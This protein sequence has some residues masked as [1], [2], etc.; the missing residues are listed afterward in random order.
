[1]ASNSILVAMKLTVGILINSVSVI[2]EAIHSAVDLI[3]ALIAMI[4]VRTS[5]RP[6]DRRHAFGHGKIENISGTVEALLI[7][8]AAGWIV[9]EAVEKLKAP[10]HMEQVSWGVLVMTFS[11]IANFYVSYRLFQVGEE[12]DSIALKADA[13]HLRTDVWTSGG[14]MAGLLCYWI[15]TTLFPQVN[16]VWVDPA[17]AIIVA[18]L[19][20]KAAYDLTLES[21]RD[22]LDARLGRDDEKLVGD[23]VAEQYPHVLS[24]HKLRTRKS[25]SQR[26]Y[27]FHLLVTPEMTVRE[28]HRIGDS[29]VARIKEHYLDAK[30]VIHVEPCEMACDDECRDHCTRM[31]GSL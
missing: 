1:V 13:W 21:V 16:L 7:F 28:S 15:G 2:S 3:A 22:L 12:T 5:G 20:V 27:E 29:I 11:A 24:F 19:I 17:A 23:Y 9:Y 8:L 30:V 14:V 6:P 31:Q 4:A 18:V 25:G 10:Q 26:F